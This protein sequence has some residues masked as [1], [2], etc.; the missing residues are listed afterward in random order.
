GQGKRYSWGYPACPDLTQHA[1]LF[2]LLGAA[3]NPALELTELGELVPEQSTAAL[4][5]HHPSAVYFA[6]HDR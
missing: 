6:M 4:V 1:L 2:D 5:V 3:R